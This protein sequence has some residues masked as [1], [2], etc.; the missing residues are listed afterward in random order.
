MSTIYKCL[1]RKRLFRVWPRVGDV[2]IDTP[3]HKAPHSS[4]GLPFDVDLFNVGPK[5]NVNL[6]VSQLLKNEALEVRKVYNMCTK[7]HLLYETTVNRFV[8]TKVVV[9]LKF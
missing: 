6:L 7:D 5:E 1:L 9:A 3:K 2:A 8:L 4:L